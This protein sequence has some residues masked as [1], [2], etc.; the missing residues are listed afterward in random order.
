[1]AA[2]DKYGIDARALAD[3]RL[4]LFDMDGTIYLDGVLFE[5]TLDL[6]DAIR[7]AGGT[8]T[9][10]T[11][12]SSRST[13]EYVER[14][15]GIGIECG[16]REI[17][18]STQASALLVGREHPGEL[19][20]VQGKTSFAAE[21][22]ELGLDVTTDAQA[23]ATVVLLGFDREL[24]TAKL[25]ATCR[26]LVE[27]RGAAGEPIPYYASHPDY[28][29]P[30]GWGAIPDLGSM[31][32]AIEHATGRM[33]RFV[34]KPAP[35]MVEMACERFGV[36]PEQAIFVGD[37]LYTDIATG[38]A[39]GIDTICVLTGEATEDDIRASEVKPTWVFDSVREICAAIS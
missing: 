34:G 8:C 32:E 3:K 24:T 23:G 11:N 14:L 5:G 21:L 18:T 35:L 38:A 20:Y 7:A 9:F 6:F 4:W 12:N 1:M 27:G 36:G 39:A 15:T 33:P 19:V 25:E 31:C 17:I 30:V 22:A 13:A 28:V 29:C 16:P 2:T 26:L 10:S 37:R